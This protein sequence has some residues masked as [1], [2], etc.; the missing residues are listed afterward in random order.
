MAA[1]LELTC[2]CCGSRE[3]AERDSGAE[4]RLADHPL[5]P[6]HTSA[7]RDGPEPENLSVTVET[8]CAGSGARVTIQ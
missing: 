7:F 6:V 8:R 2:P 1:S 4:Y 5:P 3:R